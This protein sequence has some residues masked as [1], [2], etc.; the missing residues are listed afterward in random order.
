MANIRIVEDSTIMGDMLNALL[1][2]EGHGVTV[3]NSDFATLLHP[4]PWMEV[5]AAIVDLQLGEPI[6]GFDILIY[7]Q[8]HHPTIRR[9][10]LSGSD[11]DEQIRKIAGNLAHTVLSKPA[12]IEEITDA[13][14]NLG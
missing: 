7:L 6:T 11:S 5:E 9:I 13:L 3:T 4:E 14:R 12:T 2:H 1:Q 8:A 10:V